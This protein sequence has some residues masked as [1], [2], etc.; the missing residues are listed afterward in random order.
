MYL[1]PKAATDCHLG[2]C[3]ILSPP[4]FDAVACHLGGCAIVSPPSP[5][6]AAY[7]GLGGCTL[8]YSLAPRMIVVWVVVPS[9]PSLLAPLLIVVW[10]FDLIPPHCGAADSLGWCLC[11]PNNASFTRVRLCWLNITARAHLPL[12]GWSGWRGGGVDD[13]NKINPMHRLWI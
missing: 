12:A 9:P 2:G 7:C 10:S 13:N 11:W 1:P 3:I 6:A 4:S 5:M 8:L